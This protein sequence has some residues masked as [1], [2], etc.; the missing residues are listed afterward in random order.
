ME[1]KYEVGDVVKVKQVFCDYDIY[2]NKIGIITS[3][4]VLLKS[5]DLAYDIIIAGIEGKTFY[6]FE[7]RIEGKLE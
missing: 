5:V 3:Q 2:Y 7:D 4:V 1:Y 6:I